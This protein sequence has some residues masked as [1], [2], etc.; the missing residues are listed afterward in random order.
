MGL[1]LDQMRCACVTTGITTNYNTSKSIPL[2]YT[3][4]GSSQINVV[5]SML[6]VQLTNIS[7]ATKIYAA[8]SRDTQGDEF[9][10]TE[11]RSDIQTGL[12]TNTKGT[13]LYRLDIIL[14]D[15]QD[16]VLYLHVRTNTGTTDVAVAALTYQY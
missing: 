10:M 11:T 9:V 15:I 7:S 8:I 5:A 6:E 16:K 14:R 3:K 13:V 4:Y 2:E 1:N 12:T